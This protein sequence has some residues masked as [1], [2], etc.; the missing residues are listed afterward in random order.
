MHVAQDVFPIWRKPALLTSMVQLLC[1]HTQ[2][3]FGRPDV[4]VGLDSRG[5][6]FGPMMA[7]QLGASFV[8]IRKKGKLPGECLSASYRKEYGTVRQ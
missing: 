4:I 5:F 2:A 6:L 7:A 3:R 8:P 1:L